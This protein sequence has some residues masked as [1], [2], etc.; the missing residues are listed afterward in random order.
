[1]AI[2]KGKVQPPVL[3][4]AGAVSV[5]NE[6]GKFYISC[7]L[8]IFYQLRAPHRCSAKMYPVAK[9]YPPPVTLPSVLSA[10]CIAQN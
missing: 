3:S 1:M 5:R 2:P 9:K 8:F 10:V 6:K 4:T 7:K